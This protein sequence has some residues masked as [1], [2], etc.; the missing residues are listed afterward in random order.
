MQA[1]RLHFP[2]WGGGGGK[3]NVLGIHLS[4]LLFLVFLLFRKAQ[5]GTPNLKKNEE[6]GK[7]C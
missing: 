3:S 1:P 2:S 5:K 7:A 4:L 6:N